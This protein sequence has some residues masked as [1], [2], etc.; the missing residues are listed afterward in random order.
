[1][2]LESGSPF[3]GARVMTGIAPVKRR[4][5]ASWSVLHSTRFGEFLHH[6]FLF[7]G[8]LLRNLDRDFD[9]Q[10][11]FLLTLLDSL[12]PHAESFSRGTPW[13]NLDRDFFSVQRLHTDLG[14]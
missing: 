1:M 6:P 3:R 2:S 10:I 8:Q 13:R 12:T 11:A 14:S 7:L 9:D 4:E 5:F